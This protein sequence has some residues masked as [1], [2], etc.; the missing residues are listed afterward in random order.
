MIKIV[1]AALMV[2]SLTAGAAP[3]LYDGYAVI[4]ERPMATDLAQTVYVRVKG[5]TV[6]E[7]LLELLNGTGYRLAGEGA[8]D[9][10]IGRLYAQ[11]Y[12]ESQREIGPAELGPALERLAGP[13]WQLVVD[14][15]NRLVSFEVRTAYQPG[16]AP[17]GEASAS[18]A[19]PVAP[20]I[21]EGAAKARR[22]GQR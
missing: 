19:L 8:S 18:A 2:A 5:R 6:L 20:A 22:G 9:P 11:P 7:G 15:V 1:I 4:T 12:P 13:A 21:A 14:P 16:P 3:P 17:G 10:E